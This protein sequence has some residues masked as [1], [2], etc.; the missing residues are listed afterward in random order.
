VE[1]VKELLL[2]FSSQTFAPRTI[3]A[4]GKD[5]A[6]FV[7]WCRAEKRAP[8]PADAETVL[9]YLTTRLQEGRK[10]TSARRYLTALNAEHRSHGY[11]APASAEAG[12]LLA[13]AQRVLCQQPTRKKPL[14]VE[15]ARR[16]CAAYGDT[17]ADIRDRAIITL[18][19]A[20]A[21]R[22]SSIV[23]LDLADVELV[24]RGFILRVRREKNDQKGQ[25][26]YIGVVLGHP[27]TCPVQNLRA[28]L[29]VRGEDPGPLFTRFRNRQGSGELSSSRLWPKKVSKIVK[30]GV[31]SLGLDPDRWGGH[32]LRAGLATA[33]FEAGVG[34]LRIAATTGHKSLNSLRGYIR[35]SDPFTSNVSG[36]IGM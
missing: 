24:E 21:L 29:A 31:R 36:L 14:T 5:W 25:G 1:T 16:I 33:G 22:Q 17:P 10:V 18:G 30:E 35:I 19:L 28:W 26:R 8:L 23:D 11:L 2:R 7:A 6:H 13:G 34:E 12:Q 3:D 32:S 15:Q 20:S 4:Y 9:L 27:P